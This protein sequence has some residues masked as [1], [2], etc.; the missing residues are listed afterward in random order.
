MDI[1]SRL[2]PVLLLCSLSLSKGQEGEN[3]KKRDPLLEEEMCRNFSVGIE[4][5]KEFFSPM[6]PQQYPDSIT[7][8]KTILADMS[9]FVRIDFR[10]VFHLEPMSID[11]KCE[12]DY[13]EI[14]D[15]DQGYS[16]LIGESEIQ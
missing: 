16:P 1:M 8:F 10:D 4:R 6:Y 5:S 14:R 15:G 3:S 11:G 7:C 9:Y 13:L 2:L 12:F